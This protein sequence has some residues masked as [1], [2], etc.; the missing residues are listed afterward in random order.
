MTWQIKADEITVSKNIDAINEIDKMIKFIEH[1]SKNHPE[2]Y[3]PHEV[4]QKIIILKSLKDKIGG[5]N[6]KK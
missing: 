1:H 2:E 3:G 4:Y 6:G 5:Q